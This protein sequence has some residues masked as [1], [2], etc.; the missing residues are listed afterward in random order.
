[1][2][3][4]TFTLGG[5][6]AA[7][8]IVLAACGGGRTAA[9]AGDGDDAGGGFDADATI[10]VSLP[11]LG[12]QNWAEAEDLFKAQLEDA[13]FTA[14][15]QAADNKVPQQQ[16]QIEAMVQKG[17]KAIVGRPHRRHPA[18]Q[19]PYGSEG[20]RCADHRLRPAD[21][22]H[23]RGRRDRPVRQRP[24]RRAAG[25][26]PPRRAR[27]AQGRG[28]LQHRAVRRRPG[29]PRRPEL[30]PGRDVRAPAED[31]RRHRRGP[32]RADGLPAGRHPGLG[33]RQGP[34]P[35]GFD[36]RG[37]L[38]GHADRRRAL[39][40]RRHRPRGHHLLQVRRPGCARRGRS[41]RRDRVDHLDL[42]R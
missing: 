23:R 1:M 35:D 30:L 7:S 18:R 9:D 19:R 25:P 34:V 22:E 5:V 12:T 10:G 26:V 17:A 36:P 37:E 16:Q 27:R 41:G 31:R 6:A 24:H 40:E 32:L 21:R 42:G 11:W 2:K 39:A 20:R 4:R 15:I 38:L 33:Q 29:R 13:G 28:P 14:L 8:T 3:R